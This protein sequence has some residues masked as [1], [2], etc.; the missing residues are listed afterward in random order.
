MEVKMIRLLIFYSTNKEDFCC[1][2]CGFLVPVIGFYLWNFQS[3]FLLSELRDFL[4]S[5][6]KY[7]L[8]PFNKG[9]YL[10]EYL[11]GELEIKEKDY[12]GLRYVDPSK[13]RVS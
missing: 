1:V 6:H 8:Q 7:F 3:E 13:Q 11:C 10:L 4:S 9:I 2:L 12:F 5:Y